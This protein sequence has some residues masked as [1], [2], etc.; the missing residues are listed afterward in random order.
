MVHFIKKRLQVFVSSTYLDLKEERQAAVKAILEADHIPAGMELFTSGDESQME[1]I[2]QWIEDSDVYLLILGGR[3]GSIEPSSGKSYTHLEYEYAI[4]LGKPLFACVMK[5]EYLNRKIE[6][7]N[8][9]DIM[10]QSNID[11]FNNFKNLVM[12]KLVSQCDSLA[13]I[14]YS[15]AKTMKAIDRN[16]NLGGW[17]RAN[18]SSDSALL[19]DEIAKLS[20]ENRELR[21]RIEKINKSEHQSSIPVVHGVS[22]D[23]IKITLGKLFL[24]EEDLLEVRNVRGFISEE[25]DIVLALNMIE[26]IRRGEEISVLDFLLSLSDRI[27]NN[28]NRTG[29]DIEITKI[30]SISKVK[31]VFDADLLEYYDGNHV[32]YKSVRFTDIGESFVKYVKMQAAI[33]NIVK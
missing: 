3:Y 30:T 2:K 32:M 6:G 14:Q 28:R 17:V 25:I 11:R 24:S 13:E 22:F 1:V 21:D 29:A 31:I 26:Q 5:S 18:Q 4:E 23:E 20:Q 8:Y 33:K 19:Y 12:S 7:S 16:D 15:I 10:E 27:F 9:K